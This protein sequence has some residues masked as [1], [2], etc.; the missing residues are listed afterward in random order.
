[1]AW[2]LY[3]LL[4]FVFLI[5]LPFILLIRSSLYLNQEQGVLPFL[6]IL[7]GVAIT[8]VV[9][10]IY[11]SFFYGRMAG[12]FGS[13]DTVKR[14]AF[15]AMLVV[16]VYAG[17]GIFFISASNTKSD[18]VKSE[19]S[20]LHPILRLSVSTL[21]HLDKGLIITDAE[22]GKGDYAGMGLSTN[23][24]SKHYKQK[25]GYAHAID[26]R[27]KNRHEFRNQL[28]ALYFKMMGFKTLRH[29]GT[30][31]HLHVQLK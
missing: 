16:L 3:H 17:Y 28:M 8:A 10:F 14:R 15:F 25:D 4:K 21:I 29:V 11:F 31:D 1:M 20:N 27:V 19:L 18:G 23:Q 24:S 22:R 2:F 7:G 30:A 26:L 9:M 13:F 12:R 6:S 5:T